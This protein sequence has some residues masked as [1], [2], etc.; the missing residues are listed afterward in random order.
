MAQAE[1]PKVDACS[2]AAA[3][4]VAVGMIDLGRVSEETRGICG[5]L[6]DV[7]FHLIEPGLDRD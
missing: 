2:E 6:D 5:F 1:T 7:V 3:H 4:F